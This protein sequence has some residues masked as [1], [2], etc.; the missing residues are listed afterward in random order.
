MIDANANHVVGLNNMGVVAYRQKK[1][2]AARAFFHR[3]LK[4]EPRNK[5][6]LEYLK[7]VS[8]EEKDKERGNAWSWGQ[9]FGLAPAEL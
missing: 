1:Y 7:I 5:K 3:I 2:K 4:L 6:A 9:M 8:R